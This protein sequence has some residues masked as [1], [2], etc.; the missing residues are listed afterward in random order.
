PFLF[1]LPDGRVIWAGNS[2]VASRTQVL[3]LTT[4]AWTIVDNRLID[5]ASA[6][7][8]QPGKFMKS[9]TAADSG[10]SGLAASTAFV[11]DMTKPAPAWQPPGS[12]A[13]PGAF[14]NLSSVPA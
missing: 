3:D 10:N 12:M 14:R 11:L 13:F 1:V 6:V 5:G 8:F 7:M 4:L 2:E 9:G